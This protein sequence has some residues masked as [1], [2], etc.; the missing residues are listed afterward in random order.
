MFVFFIVLPL[1]AISLYYLAQSLES[2]E[3]FTAL[4]ESNFSLK[5]LFLSCLI[6][7]KYHI[8]TGVRHMLMD[9]HLISESLNAAHRSSQITLMLFLVDSIVTILV[10]L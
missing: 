8:F 10:V 9:F 1:T 3:Q 7:F 4:I 2:Y 5:F 6:I